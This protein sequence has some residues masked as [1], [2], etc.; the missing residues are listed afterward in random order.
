M[1]GLAPILETDPR[2]ICV[3][4]KGCP[5]LK[6]KKGFVFQHK[7]KGTKHKTN[8]RYPGNKFLGI[9]TPRS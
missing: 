3:G 4:L 6:K 8:N 7:S 5:H 1:R 9:A 2:R